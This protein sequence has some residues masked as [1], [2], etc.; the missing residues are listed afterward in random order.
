MKVQNYLQTIGFF[1]VGAVLLLLASCSDDTLVDFSESR[2]E[3]QEQSNTICADPSIYEADKTLA[4]AD[5][6]GAYAKTRELVC[7]EIICN[8]VPLLFV[9]FADRSPDLELTTEGTIL[10]PEGP[11]KNFE[12]WSFIAAED[13]TLPNRLELV[14]AE[15][16][17]NTNQ[18]TILNAGP[19]RVRFE[20]MQGWI[21]YTR[22]E[23]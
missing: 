5:F 19:C 3:D 6:I 11:F 23:E 12:T 14:D 10:N 16:P 17:D 2:S 18:V 1:L 20:N 13:A 8:E 4:A 22:L 21:E 7:G 9:Q 15:T